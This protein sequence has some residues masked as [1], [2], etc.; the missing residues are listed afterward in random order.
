MAGG[1]S[2][3]ATE[4]F[5]LPSIFSGDLQVAMNIRRILTMS[6]LAILQL[7]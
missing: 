4:F 6:L 1:V 2:R 3:I 7:Q 5:N